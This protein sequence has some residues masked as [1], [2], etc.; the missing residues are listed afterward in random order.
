MDALE[1]LTA[2]QMEV[3]IQDKL[4]KVLDL[5]PVLSDVQVY[6]CRH[7]EYDIQ[8]FANI[9]DNERLRIIC[10]VKSKGEPKLIRLTATRLLDIKK[11]LEKNEG[12][13]YFCLSGAPYISVASSKICEEM[14]VG[15]VDLA[16]NCLMIYDGIY[17]RV[18]GQP[19]KYQGS[20]GK[21]NAIFERRSIKS[22]KIL[23]LL[24]KY[25]E[26]KWKMQDLAN[27]SNASVGQIANVKRYL[28]EREYIS[29]DE[30][31]FFV[32]KPRDI[33]V[34]WAKTY[35]S[36]PN[37]MYEYYL[38]GSTQEIEQ[39]LIEMKAQLGVEYAVTGFS[40]A[41]RY[42]PVVRYNKVHAYV[43]Y[44]DLQ[45]AIAWLGCK[46]VNSGSNISIIVPYDPC[47]MIDAHSINNLM[48]ASP[49]QVCLDL[50][51]LKGRGDEAA[52]A[53]MEKEF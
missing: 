26:K 49:V 28:E 27:A 6:G 23:R 33:I 34:D 25:P 17:I 11:Q 22:S 12:K 47:T 18:E 4:L 50:L 29:S 45:D 9:N 20:K 30:Q 38:G 15:F 32:M 2:Q 7:Q 8:A 36:K 16:G 53:I 13:R 46:Q 43:A 44:Q 40:G 52:S 41:V 5:V 35:N 19:N 48:V 31:G 10:Q 39:K 51:G 14:G 24:L 42:S 37:E 21:N 1:S 3:R